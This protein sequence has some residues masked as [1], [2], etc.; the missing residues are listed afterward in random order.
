MHACIRAFVRPPA[1]RMD[2]CTARNRHA[3]A[4]SLARPHPGPPT[5]TEFPTFTNVPASSPYAT[6]ACTRQEASKPETLQACA[7]G[8]GGA[9]NR[10]AR[11]G[12]RVPYEQPLR[13]EASHATRGMKE[14]V[15][16][17]RENESD[18]WWHH[19]R[20]PTQRG[21]LLAAASWRSSW[22]H[23]LHQVHLI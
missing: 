5:F 22:P 10:I 21:I 18:P 19:E 12:R 20:S 16:R 17:A 7:C 8:R 6:A 15:R 14:G 2:H 11:A 1:Q 9:L 13:H 4:R 3:F 23:V